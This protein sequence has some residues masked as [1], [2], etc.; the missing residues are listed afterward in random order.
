[1]TDRAAA[2]ASIAS[3]I[4]TYRQDDKHLVSP[5]HVDRWAS[6][7]TP[8]NQLAFLHEVGY[9]LRQ[10]FIT[11]AAMEAFLKILLRSAKVAGA[12]PAE[13]WAKA[14]FLQIQRAG[15]SQKEM[16]RLFD[17]VLQ[18]TLGL[19][20]ANCGAAGGDY[21]YLDDVL[22][23]GG[24]VGTDLQDWI[25]KHAPA[26]AKVQVIVM[27]LHTSGHHFL[28]TKRLRTAIERSGKKITIDFRYLTLSENMKP[29][30]DQSNVLW[31]TVVPDDPAVQAYNNQLI[32]D[33]AY[34]L[35]PRT[36]G[37]PSGVFSS[38]QGRQLLE[39]EFVV[40]GVKIRSLKPDLNSFFRPLGCSNFGMG[41]GSMITTYRNCSNNCPLAIWW[42]DPT[43]K[44]GALNWYPL[45]SRKTYSSVE[46][47]LNGFDDIKF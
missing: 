43:E 33:R 40:A 25:A 46:N 11:Q 39:H 8:A 1:M 6:Q 7:F 34:P 2:L 32:A 20:I 14:N 27:A 9:V 26:K 36:V 23:T 45:L 37:G 18:Q 29:K 28:R 24:R 16:L 4:S 15:Q 44:Q 22:F 3:T 47:L 17:G 19:R 21:I 5:D 42:G 35:E 41:F 38:E 10:T 12:N 31:P 13:F 30:R